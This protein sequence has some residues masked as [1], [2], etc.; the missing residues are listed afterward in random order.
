MGFD[1][2]N[3]GFGLLVGWGSAYAVY[4][5]RHLMQGAASSVSRGA[6][7]VQNST[8]RS[9]DSRYVSDLIDRANST[10]LGGL[11][12][13]LSDVIIE[14]RFIPAPELAVPMDDAELAHDIF[15]VIPTIHDHPYLHAPYNVDTLSIDDLSTG[16]RALALLGLPGSGRTTALLSIA[17]HSLG[18][19]KFE[20]P[21]DKIQAK[22]DSE[23]A[24]M[25]E[26]ERSVRVKERILI[27]Q[28][29]RERL[30]N[31]QGVAFDAEADEEMRSALPLFRRLM[32]VYVHF[33]DLLGTSNEFGTEVDPAEPIV[34]AVQYNVRRVTASTIPRAMYNRFNK[35][36]ILL[37]V[38]GYDDLPEFERPRALAWLK[39]FMEQ[40][41]QNFVI[42]ASPINGFGT[43]T[44][45]GFTPVFVRPWSDL[46]ASH[47]VERWADVWSRMDGKR[48]RRAPARPDDAALERAH[49]NN[50]ALLPVE[51]TMKLWAS[52]TGKVEMA[53]YE[54]WVRSTLTRLIPPDQPLAT[55]LPRLSQ[56]A[57]VQ[58]EEGYIT[59]AR[60]Q[61]LSIGGAE[62]DTNSAEP[63]PEQPEPSLEALAEEANASTKDAKKKKKGAADTEEDTETR[64]AQ[65][66]LLASLR[67]CGL[68]VRYRGDRYQ[69]RHPL[70]A[71]YL[72][73][74][75]LKQASAEELTAR[76]NQPAWRQAVAYAALHTP[77][78]KIVRKRMSA[79]PD[80]LQ[81]NVVE[82][83]RWL[84]YA[85]VDAAWR[86][87]VLK[88]LGNLLV[89]PNQYPL[90]RERAA[91]ALLDSRDTNA[92][93]VFRR[94][95][96][97]VNADI[98]RL[99]C[100]GMGA[101]GDP[102]AIRDLK[103]LIRDQDMD[104]QLASGMALGAIGNEEAL[105]TMLIAFTEGSEQVRQA[106][107]EAFAAM[108][109]EGYPILAEAVED[110]DMMLRR[111]AIFGL[112][113]I[114]T[115][116]ALIAIYRAF[117]EDEQWYVRSAAQQ[118]FQEIQYGRAESPTAAYPSP[119]AIAWL[120]EWAASR[121][122]TMPAG[123]GAQQMLL[124]ALQEGDPPIRTLAA[125]NLGQLGLANMSKAL[126]SALRDRQDEVR[127]AAHKSL[128]ELQLQIGQ[129]L[130]T[131][132]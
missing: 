80:V 129:S 76:L 115:T 71:A 83:G 98:R 117:L 62:G 77:V 75:T 59:S 128:G 25:S 37:L 14:P 67:K 45:M 60:M 51:V 15:R 49:A 11:N 72:A 112:R 101:L 104:V 52:Y 47:A 12:V 55:L 123:D 73:S 84:A 21:A 109:E 96:R 78:D 4:R 20:P 114:R 82:L 23:E 34:R 88:T 106:M 116:W 6:S 24:A 61:A 64:T 13:K 8:T 65:G 89:M 38:D 119:E 58:L 7:N 120:A 54:G 108:P 39:A 32:P 86:G 5:A 18:A 99:S 122:E 125:L 87:D 63:E 93:L 2:E 107:A 132:A 100:L 28:R 85:P 130:P 70:L 30:A 29:A 31:E 94:A 42:V 90:I 9:A 127:A 3:F 10:H 91:A 46:N 35:G 16:N 103:P 92:L 66:R 27:E 79:A 26:K 105:E 48:G 68:L 111:A 102:E 56:I 1:L 124:R 131:P 126:Y 50:R 95:V 43:I 22:L 81:N 53:G 44:Q 41:S 33:A 97:N 36:Q 121:G 118:A 17:L 19:L 74:L 113:R 40:Y 110:Q 69:F 57:A